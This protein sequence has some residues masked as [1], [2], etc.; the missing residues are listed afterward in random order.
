MP[1]NEFSTMNQWAKSHDSFWNHVLSYD[2][3]EDSDKTFEIKVTKCLWAKTFRENNA[4]EI[5]YA[6][7]CHEDFVFCRTINPRVKLIRYKTL[8][9]GNDCCDF[10]W[11]LED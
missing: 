1:D 4:A 3:I 10:K 8:M 7:K 6:V 5:G 9:Q 11:V 2:I